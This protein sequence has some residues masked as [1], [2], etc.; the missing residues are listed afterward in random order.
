MLS[1]GPSEESHKTQY[2]QKTNLWFLPLFHFFN[3]FASPTQHIESPLPPYWTRGNT[4]FPMGDIEYSCKE[5]EVHSRVRC[6]QLKSE[7]RNIG[8]TQNPPSCIERVHTVEM[9]TSDKVFGSYK[10][11]KCSYYQDT[12]NGDDGVEGEV[13]MEV[14]SPEFVS[15]CCIGSE[16]TS[17]V[18][19]S[20]RPHNH[21]TRFLKSICLWLSVSLTDS[22]H[23]CYR[24]SASSSS[25]CLIQVG[26]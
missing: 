18:L 7:Q 24:P 14:E 16:W 1:R 9:I 4:V 13:H 23:V 8:R 17:L 19:D 6:R 22:G 2:T 11:V 15:T 21:D 25:Y 5:M 10:L 3:L 26:R 12:K 20:V